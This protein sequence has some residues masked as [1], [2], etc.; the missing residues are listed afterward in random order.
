[1]SGV[2]G[3]RPNQQVSPHGGQRGDVS[4]QRLINAGR[5]IILLATFAQLGQLLSDLRLLHSHSA[6]VLY[7]SCY[8]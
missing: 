4:R 3:G 6:S 2:V 8:P 5:I 1:M 7:P